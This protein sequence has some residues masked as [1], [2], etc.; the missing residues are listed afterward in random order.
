M[1]RTIVLD[2]RRTSKYFN[3]IIKVELIVLASEWLKIENKTE[4]Q[5]TQ[6]DI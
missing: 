6:I 1:S 2:K 4:R 5:N 3:K